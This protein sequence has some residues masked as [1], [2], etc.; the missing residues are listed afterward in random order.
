MQYLD[1][2]THI[3]TLRK[4]PRNIPIVA[5]PGAAAVIGPLGFSNVII[6][7]HGE[8]VSVANGRLT[9]TASSGALVGP[10]WSHRQ[11]G[12]TFRETASKTDGTAASLYYEPHCD[13]DEYSVSSLGR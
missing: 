2:H 12:V 13:F 4:L 6:I 3:P 8:S 10:P 7:D 11:N 1:D 9:V 5:N